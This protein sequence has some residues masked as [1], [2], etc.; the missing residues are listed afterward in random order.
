MGLEQVGGWRAWTLDGLL[1]PGSS[2]ELAARLCD[3]RFQALVLDAEGL[4]LSMGRSVRLFEPHQRRAIAIRD[5]GCVMPGC[6]QPVRASH[7]HHIEEHE[8]DQGP[9]DVVN[10]A[11]LCARDHGVP[12]RAGWDMF[13]TA[14]GW[15][16]FRTPTGHT[17]WGQRHGHQR[18][19][20]TPDRRAATNDGGAHAPDPPRA[21]AITSRTPVAP[22]CNDAGAERCAQL[23]S[24]AERRRRRNRCDPWRHLVDADGNALE[25]PAHADLNAAVVTLLGDLDPVEVIDL[26]LEEAS[27]DP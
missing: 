1:L 16:W 10:G 9:T 25:P 23:R 4:P 11:G 8:R 6:T 3:A 22:G 5:G 2:P 27:H 12:H 13:M 20:P 14:D 17:F 7:I 18:E 21:E 19:G 24:Q 15:P 26:L